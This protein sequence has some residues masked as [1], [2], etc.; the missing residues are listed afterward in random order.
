MAFFRD[1]KVAFHSLMR[2]KG[3]ATIVVLTLALGIG[4][5][6]AIFTL[7][8]GVLL[9]PLVNRD[10]NRLIYIRQ[11]APRP[12]RSDNATSPSPK[13]RTSNP[14]STPS[15]SSAIS[16]QMGFTMIGLG[17]PRE[18]RGGVV[19]GNY[20]EVMGLHPVL[21]RLSDRKTTAPTRP[22]S[23]FSRI[24]SGRPSSKKIPA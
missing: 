7:V 2:S 6:A 17:E 15:T 20:F 19:S 10:E 3:L 23:S 8:R 24:A 21:G 16:R 18:V 1:L 5:N 13:S 4:A 9:K 12:R 11:S 14:A 22:A